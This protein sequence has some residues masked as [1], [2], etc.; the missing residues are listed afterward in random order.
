MA[1]DPALLT[2]V[3]AVLTAAG[4]VGG[5]MVSRR[6]ARDG[7]KVELY[8]A[9]G[10]RVARVEGRQDVL[11]RERAID[12]RWIAELRDHIYRGA[13]PPPPERPTSP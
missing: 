12:Q 10:E 8:R 6:T 2:A 1:I 13:P 7:T 5:H 4:A 9:M 3:G 11:E